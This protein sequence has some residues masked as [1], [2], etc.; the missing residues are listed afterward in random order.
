[1]AITLNWTS[2]V[3]RQDVL[4]NPEYYKLG[5]WLEDGVE[6]GKV[7]VPCNA[8]SEDIVSDAEVIASIENSDQEWQ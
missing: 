1:M 3:T 8:N 2:M 6:R 4:G 7:E 5:V